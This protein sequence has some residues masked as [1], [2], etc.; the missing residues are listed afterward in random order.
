MAAPDRILVTGATGFVGGHLLPA[1]RV[2][3]PEAALLALT[4][5]NPAAAADETFHADLC[6]PTSLRAALTAARPDAILHLAAQSSVP[7]AFIDPAATWRVNVDGTL[8]LAALAREILPAVLFVFVGSAEAY[9]LTFQRGT[10]LDENAP[11]APANPYAASKAA[12]DI[13]LGEMALRGLHVLRLRPFN[14]TGMGQAPAFA[15]PAFARQLARI[16][17]GLQDR[18]VKVGALDRW[19]DFLDVRDVCAGYIAALR[20]GPGITPGTAINLASGT[21]RRIGDVLDALIARVDFPVEVRADAGHLR[22]TD[23]VTATGDPGRAAALL[24]WA[25]TIAWDATLDAVLEDCRKRFGK[26]A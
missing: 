8:T 2:A 15:V 7:A 1:L 21:P 14:H 19:R 13:A 17:A 12:A 24:D 4:Q 16:E 3:F 20:H 22:P 18:V 6:D 10:P 25:P 23:V 9:G 11:F 5:C 26:E